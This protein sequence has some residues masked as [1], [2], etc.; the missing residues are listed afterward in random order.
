MLMS[1]LLLMVGFAI[2][3]NIRFLESTRTDVEETQLARAILEKISR[4]IRS[5]VVAKKEEDLKIDESIFDSMFQ[6]SLG[7]GVDE[8]AAVSG[9][10]DSSS[11]S[12]DSSSSSESSVSELPES[13]TVVG[14]MPGIYGSIDW[15]QIDTGRLPRGETFQVESV[16]SE[17]TSLMDHI[18]PTKTAL[19]YIG[20]DT[21]TLS[22]EESTIERLTGS[23]GEPLDRYSVQYGLYRRQLDRNVCMYAEENGLEAEYETYDESLAPEVE[24][25]EFYYYDVNEEEWIDYWDMDEFGT[26]PAAVRVIVYIR[27]K[28]S[29]RSVFS[30][31]SA[32]QSPETLV[33]STIVPMPLS[34]EAPEETE[35]EEEETAGSSATSS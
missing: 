26:L 24:G 3:T 19:Y 15:I 33:F 20:E 31:N 16:L 35:E 28:P 21:G 8:L 9:S 12:S 18:S 27:Q 1:V 13:G 5:V 17:G 22:A 4:D 29:S 11:S 7:M 23:L 10:T 14:T 30:F 6:D 32:R 34:Y 25:I 2:D